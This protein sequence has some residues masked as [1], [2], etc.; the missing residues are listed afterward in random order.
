MAFSKA[1]P[2]IRARWISALEKVHKNP[3]VIEAFK[4]ADIDLTWYG[5][6]RTTK[7][8]VQGS[9]TIVKYVDLVKKK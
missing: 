8:Y 2:T 7:L 6:D 9:N 3:E 5:A 4:K 1:N